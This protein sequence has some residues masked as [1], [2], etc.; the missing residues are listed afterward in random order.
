[1]ANHKGNNP[2]KDQPIQ[3]KTCLICKS[4]FETRHQGQ[5][6]CG[7]HSFKEIRHFLRS[8]PH[9]RK[10]IRYMA[11]RYQKNKWKYVKLSIK[12]YRA[13]NRH[14]YLAYR[15]EYYKRT[16]PNFGKVPDITGKYPPGYPFE[17]DQLE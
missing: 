14:K 3:T 6:Y 2:Y 1:M 16:H 10:H 7:K 11:R 4:S 9:R 8:D 13:K 5:K 12:R 17:S 15:R